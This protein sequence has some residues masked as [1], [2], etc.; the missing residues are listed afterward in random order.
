MAGAK[1]EPL[2][3][4]CLGGHKNILI[5]L[6]EVD[7]LGTRNG[8]QEGA[9]ALLDALDHDQAFVDR[10][11]DLPIDLSDI[12]FIATA[13]NSSNIPAALYDRMNS[14]EIL[15][16]SNQ[17]KLEI[18]MRHILPKEKEAYQLYGN[19]LKIA[20]EVIQKIVE[21]DQEN[22]GIRGVTK[23]IRKICR[24][25]SKELMK[26]GT[27][28]YYMSEKRAKEF[29]LI[30]DQVVRGIIDDK[31]GNAVTSGFD[32]STGREALVYV[33]SIYEKGREEPI[34]TG[35]AKDRYRDDIIQLWSYMAANHE[36]LL[37][38]EPQLHGRISCKCR[39]P[40]PFQLESEP[41]LAYLLPLLGDGE[42]L[43]S[44]TGI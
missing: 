26:K 35:P 3:T 33:E 29:G 9:A 16:Y 42:R 10:F 41:P 44:P 1:P 31:T 20:P 32:Y 25:A 21:S 6:D 13:N 18:C 5:L 36:M 38:S 22:A 27:K 28:Y 40:Q 8:V 17:D 14:I 11:I 19:Q 12:V 37:I 4:F 2:W 30:P 7:K 39:R 23:K 24:I 15:P 34:V 43:S